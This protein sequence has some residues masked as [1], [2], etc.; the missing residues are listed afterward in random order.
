M[1][2]MEDIHNALKDKEITKIV[3]L[4]CKRTNSQRQ[5][6]KDAYYSTWG[7]DLLKELDSKLSGN[8]QKLILGLMKTPED[9]DANELYYSFLSFSRIN[10]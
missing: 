6:I 1:T 2:D 3:E 10:Y 9:F 7:T 4:I 8:I 5:K